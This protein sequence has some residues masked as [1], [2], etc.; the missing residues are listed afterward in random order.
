MDNIYWEFT[1][2]QEFFTLSFFIL[3]I[4]LVGKHYCCPYFTDQNN[5]LLETLSN[6]T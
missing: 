6:V 5:W 4:V 1:T 3:T 2:Y